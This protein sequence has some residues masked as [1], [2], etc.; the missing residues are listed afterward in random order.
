MKFRL[1]Y[2]GVLRSTQGEA[3]PHQTEPLA[4]HKHHIRREIHKQLKELWRT[5]PFLSTHKVSRA[6][7]QSR[8]V[9]DEDSYWGTDPKEQL[10]WDMAIADLYKENGYRFV[11]LVRDAAHLLCSLDI[12]FLRRDTPGSIIHAGDIDN[13]IK[14]VI[15]ALRKP[16]NPN[17]LKGN[18]TPAEGEDPFYCLL[19]D[20]RQVSH[21]SVETDR[22]LDPPAPKNTD[23]SMVRLVITVNVRPYYNTLLNLMFA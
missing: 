17:E 8:P 11:P 6:D 19:E 21:L 16:H 22:L 5:E 10:P 18:E 4:A 2:E 14:T 3:R 23:A 9:S 1:T 20:D 7:A 12:L 13:R 15:D